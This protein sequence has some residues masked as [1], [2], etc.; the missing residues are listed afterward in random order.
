MERVKKIKLLKMLLLA[1]VVLFMGCIGVFLYSKTTLF[2]FASSEPVAK[3]GANLSKYVNYDEEWGKGT[4][5]QYNVKAG[6]EYPENEVYTPIKN[7]TLTLVAPQI[8]GFYPEKVVVIPISTKA[9]NGKQSGIE[10]NYTYDVSTGTIAIKASNVDENGNVVYTKQYANAQDEYEIILHYGEHQ[11]NGDNIER[12]LLMQA[13]VEETYGEEDNIAQENKIFS[14]KV[15]QNI[16]QVVSENNNIDE[17]FN[18]YIKS[19]IINGTDYGTRYKQTDEIVISKKEATPRISLKDNNTFI[20]QYQNKA[21]E[22]AT[23]EQNNG[24]LTIKSTKFIK[25]ELVKLLG[26]DGVVQILDLN[27]KLITE[28]NKDTQVADDGTLTITYENEPEGI[29]VKTSNIQSEGILHVENIKEIKSTILNIENIKVKTVNQAS[30]VNEKITK[31]QQTQEDGSVVETEEVTEEEISLINNENVVE[32]KDA[33]TNTYIN[34]SAEE[35]TNENQNEVTF[36]ISLGASSFKDN[37]LKNPTVKIEFPSQVEKVILGSSNAIYANGLT[38]SDPYVETNAN[39]NICIVAN[40]VGNQTQYNENEL[41]LTTSIK[42]PATLILKKDIEST[43]ANIHVTYTNEF[44]ITGETESGTIEK[45]I[46]IKSY[47]DKNILP[48]KDENNNVIYNSATAGAQTIEGLKVD[49]APVRGNV[50]LA[51]GDTVYEGEYIKYN[52]KVTNT[53]DASMENVKIIGLVPEGTTYGELEADYHSYN[54]EYTYNFDETLTAKNIEIGTLQPGNTYNAFYE[55]K[56]NDLDGEVEKTI[57]SSITAYAG[58]AKGESYNQ[59]NVLKKSEAKVFVRAFLDNAKDRWDYEVTVTG[60]GTLKLQMPDIFTCTYVANG[61]TKWDSSAYEISE[62]NII[63][64]SANS[65][66]YIIGGTMDSLKLAEETEN[67]KVE[68]TAVATLTTNNATYT[69]NENRILFEYDS[70]SVSITSEN[71]GEEVKYGEEINYQIVVE[72]TGSTNLDI[73]AYKSINVKLTD[74]LPENVNPIS[75]K[76]ENWEEEKTIIDETT[77]SYKPTGIF[78]KV[79]ETKDISGEKTDEEGNKLAEIEEY[80]T[81]PYGESVVIDVKTTAG[82]MYEKTKIENTATV[83]GDGIKAKTSNTVSHIILPY[84]YEEPGTPEVPVDPDDPDPDNPD[85]DNPDP[86][87]PNPDDEKYSISGLAW[88]DENEDG[89]RQL[90]E[91]VIS[92]VTA[93]LVDISDSSKVYAKEL[94]NSNGVYSF[95]KLKQG[96]YIIVFEY[97]ANT[98]RLTKYH[99]NGVNTETNSDATENTIT[100][101]GKSIKAGVT[102]TINL[103][104][105]VG[106]IDVGL[107]Q[108]KM[109]D[110]KL[111]K[112][113]SKVTVQTSKNTKEQTYNN[114]N[115]AKTEIRS[116]EIEGANVV[117]E[118]KIVI[119][120]EG[121]FASIVGEVD[122]YIPDGLNFSSEL[123]SN[124]ATKGNGVIIN[125]S[126]SNKEIKPG[127]SVELTLVLTKKMTANS[128]GSFI[129]AAE[130]G[131]INNS[132]GIKDKDSTPSNKVQTED[133]YSE[134]ELII[135]ISTG[136]VY[137]YLSIIIGLLTIIGIATYLAKR[138]GIIKLGKITLF[139]SILVA[140]IISGNVT[141]FAAPGTASFCW[142]AYGTMGYGNEFGSTYFWGESYTGDALCTQAGVN[143][144]GWGG[145]YNGY[146]YY[147][148]SKTGED[149]GYW[150]DDISITMTKGNST[151][152]IKELG[153]NYILGPFE[154]KC[155]NN[156]GYGFEVYDSKGNTLSNYTTTDANG[157]DIWAGG[158]STFYIRIAKS[159][160]TNGI[161]RVKISSTKE[162]NRHHWS[163]TDGKVYYTPGADY[164][165]V[166]TM[167]ALRVSESNWDENISNTKSIEWTDFN[168]NLELIKQDSDNSDVKLEGV[169]LRVQNTTTGFDQTVT[170]DANG[171]AF[172]ENLSTNGT[173][174]ITEISNP[175]YGY[176]VDA[177]MTTSIQ[178]GKTTV[179]NITN[180]KQTGNLKIVKKDTDTGELLAGMEFKVKDAQ[181]KYIKAV[182][183][184]GKEQTRVTGTIYLGDIKTTTSSAVATTFVTDNKG[185]I[186]IRNILVGTYTVE[187][188]SVGNNYYGYDVDG[189][190]ITSIANGKTYYGTELSVTVQRQ[191]LSDTAFNNTNVA[192]NKKDVVEVKN[193][194]KYVKTS[195]YVWED[196][197][198]LNGKERE[199]DHL[200]TTNVDEEGNKDKLLSGITVRLKDKDENVLQETATADDGSYLFKDVLINGLKDYYLEYEYDGEVYTTTKDFKE[201][202]Y[203]NSN[204]PSNSSK[205]NEVDKQ[206][207]DLDNKYNQIAG[208]ETLETSRNSTGTE[209]YGYIRDKQTGLVYDLKTSDLGDAIATYNADK[210]Q[211]YNVNKITSNTKETGYNVLGSDTEENI[212]KTATTELENR[213]CGLMVREQV[214]LSVSSDVENVIFSVNGYT[215]TYQYGKSSEYKDMNEFRTAVKVKKQSGYTRQLYSSDIV[216]DGQDTAQMWITY[217]MVIHNN[218]DTVSTR[219]YE[220]ANYYDSRYE[221]EA[222]GTTKELTGDVTWSDKNQYGTSYEKDSIGYVG[223][224]TTSLKDREILAGDSTTIY[225]KYKLSNEA[226]VSVL[227]GEFTLNDVI[228]INGYSTQYGEKTYYHSGEGTRKDK[229]YAGIDIDSAPGNVKLDDITTY[230]DDTAIAPSLTVSLSEGERIITGTVFEDIQTQESKENNERLGDG[231]YNE[232]NDY[233][234]SGVK[235]DLLYYEEPDAQEP[236]ATLYSYKNSQKTK[237]TATYTTKEDGTY[238]FAGV[239]PDKYIIRFTYADGNEVYKIANNEKTKTG[240][241]NV[242][243]YKSTI[244]TSDIIKEA[245]NNN[246]IVGSGATKDKI[247][248]GTEYDSDKWYL[249]NESDE[250]YSDAIDVKDTIEAA[251]DDSHEINH[252]NYM[253]TTYDSGITEKNAY[254]GVMNVQVEYSI[255]ETANVATDT[256][257]STELVENSDGTYKVVEYLSNLTQNL[258]FGIAQKAKQSYNINKEISNLK[259]ILANGQVLID[260]NPSLGNVQY[261][262]YLKDESGR[263]TTVNV[264]VNDEILYGSTLQITYRIK[265]ENTSETNYLTEDYYIYGTGK[266][267]SKV[268]KVTFTKLIDYLDDDLV[269]EKN[270]N[271]KI[272]LIDIKDYEKYLTEDVFKVAKTFR[273]VMLLTSDKALVPTKYNE[274][275]SS[276]VWEYQVSKI[277]ATSDDL[278]YT[279]DVEEIEIKT[280]PTPSEESTPGNYDPVDSTK[281]TNK[282]PDNYRSELTITSPTGADRSFEKYIIG[283]T[284]LI[285]LAGGIIIIKRKAL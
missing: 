158:N 223:S 166:L 259:L 27:N 228:E 125:T 211:T 245:L 85:P 257:T 56:V 187:E 46:Q 207:E 120:N 274:N 118:Y 168:G 127:E 265:A 203:D 137:V 79:T 35:W 170:T 159:N 234:V 273:T 134:A 280:T 235:V 205:S 276:E 179:V 175:N 74:Y 163:Y 244:I 242:D 172:I 7:T 194:R 210:S 101:N 63:T 253:D 232:E 95:D 239:V 252:S 114:S 38:L 18:G 50:N 214:D 176:N 99:Q 185:I 131:S 5:I 191:N 90:Q 22:E 25:E 254:T 126:M 218:S 186:E 138:F 269:Y 182:D 48:T 139:S 6:I 117:C 263:K 196:I 151:I 28:I 278:D 154:V 181:G 109:C 20:K 65:G 31:V 267:E 60:S 275:E 190:Y 23:E 164:Q 115:L 37:M 123:N 64:F 59:L 216:Y 14:A 92:G 284:A 100:L 150:D 88:V 141:S 1:F 133:D 86:D 233:S 104:A 200:Y 221:I 81:I 83:T 282:E 261:V 142:D 197:K 24:T 155:S 54:G 220:L 112:Y 122:D 36:D 78:N 108:N 285:V 268:E 67:S 160:C 272:T 192:D 219:V 255:N 69:S 29:I 208:K 189:D 279:N 102:D 246:T 98:Y 260:G 202:G 97:D 215:N 281:I 71:E 105:S 178:K 226:L 173:Y 39:G 87:N 3:L 169:K 251:L 258:D 21:G 110:F 51:D 224:Y 89:Q 162:G 238:V 167:N 140:I 240:D 72:N 156:A 230:E 129:N 93:M 130:I 165:D 52:I 256:T 55:V 277:L 271:D 47:Q 84:N 171:R 17:I 199:N 262:K 217:K 132:Q 198:Q 80:F 94:T 209:G 124:W 148:Y 264:E 68:L 15:N 103:E 213:N 248:T 144:A 152:G 225:V 16:G 75:M 106:N 195:G 229:Q 53:T 183:T 9:T 128:T 157:N 161:S 40:L 96:S 237:E 204:A 184:K 212:R 2:S 62:D 283:A 227:S 135:S 66:S 77:G 250:R 13:T 73:P 44:N 107:I 188:T 34:V 201:L 174:V 147:D 136:A 49:V 61:G 149:S 111:D 26:T 12:E 231:K 76:Y 82:F 91:N 236:A 33:K 45:Q 113:I 42:I 247:I 121:E 177:K 180:I 241:V 119:T 222:S 193:Q 146:W 43:E 243:Y 249:I 153:N 58:E 116:K 143:A 266:D 30:A 32:I 8:D 41:G 11:Y 145:W 57:T 270:N 4:L 19:N 206:R 10:S 70:A